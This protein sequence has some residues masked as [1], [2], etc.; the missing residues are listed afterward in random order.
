MPDEEE[1][2]K[3]TSAV[4]RLLT[5]WG[6]R[7]LT[8]IVLTALFVLLTH[9]LAG[10]QVTEIVDSVRKTPHR[11]F[12]A[13]LLFSGI[14]YVALMGYD[15]CAIHTVSERPIRASTIAI[16]SFC[17]YAV[18][19]TLGFPLLT[20]GAV[21]WRIYGRA[22]MSLSAVA[23]LTVIANLTLWMGMFV[24]L[25]T[26]LVFY[27]R[28]MAELNHLSLE[29]NKGIGVT[30]LLVLAAFAGWCGSGERFL[31]K[32][33]AMLPLPNARTVIL[34]IIFGFVDVGAAAAA[35]WVFLPPEANISF[36]S[37][38]AI[39]SASIVLAI[40]SHLPAGI[41]AFE[42]VVL[43]AMPDVPK[44]HVLSA[45]LL[46]RVTYNLIPFCCA[47][48]LFGLYEA[49]TAENALGRTLRHFRAAILP[50][51]PTVL[52]T[53]TFIGG[54]VLL[55][56]GVVPNYDSRI[57]ILR[58]VVPLPFSEVSHLIGSMAGVGLLVLSHGL[59]KRMQ[60][61]WF[62]TALVL[63]AGIVVSLLKGLD[64]EEATVLAVILMLLLSFQQ[65]FY[66]K[67]ALFSEPLSKGMVAMIVLFVIGSIWLGF[68]AYTDVGYRNQLWWNFTWHDDAS[69]FLRSTVVVVMLC[70]AIGF[71]I[72]TGRRPARKG[73]DTVPYDQLK[74]ILEAATRADANLALLGD[75]RFLFHP[76]GDAFLMYR[77]QGKSWIVM[78]DPVGHHE[79]AADLM[80]TFMEE[81]DKHGGCPVFYQV[82]TEN[83]PL[84]LDGGFTLVKLGEEAKVDIS[85]FTIDG[86]AG[87][88]WRLA[89]NKAT[90]NNLVFEIIP[91]EKVPEIIDEL[92]EVSDLWLSERGTGE[93]GFSVGAWSEEYVSRFDIAVIRQESQII[94]FANL[95][96]SL[97]RQELTVDLMRYIPQEHNVMDLL[98]LQVILH[99]KE[100]GLR[101]FNLG[102]APLT[103][104][105]PH[106]LAPN[107]HKIATF[108]A[109]NSE[110]FY[111]F[112]GLRAYK[113]KFKPQ[114]EPR[115]LAYP[116]GWMLPQ[117][118]I[119]VTALI[120]GG[121]TRTLWKK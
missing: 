8:V 34:Q 115:Y 101:W 18:G 106:R 87:K 15:A 71:H 91:R 49:V 78:G 31:G 107:W 79:H 37:L 53:L 97:P 95:W 27:P 116:G 99:G 66:R 61:A 50:I 121:V 57:R 102:M 96:Q 83:I 5:V 108:V 47:V 24:V 17:S 32:G 86:K 4:R 55:V 80:W 19:Q 69:R 25:G 82:S 68:V 62:M 13:A 12:A 21:R 2:A 22:G 20:A 81:A 45:L 93:K 10:L 60:T 113:N 33:A 103:G 43:L 7:V 72:I 59:I 35:L 77:V 85:K 67:G 41:G 54:A 94:A 28:T 118:L 120:S 73:A 76:A 52:G 58:L 38:A 1:A 9:L 100:Q 46:W 114:W 64:W 56:S 14:S 23:K 104:L 74:G 105:S 44:E 29:V 42:A 90:K 117:I 84:Y 48:A 65:A 6:P 119:D 36:L 75:K 112:S 39:F 3:E 88:D 111:G 98:L 26:A 89:L 110:R 16:G 92:K 109:R 51:V 30:L 70:A 11:V 63:V 40:I